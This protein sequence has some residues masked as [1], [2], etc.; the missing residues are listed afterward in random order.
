MTN[1]EFLKSVGMEIKVARI[2]KG[3]SQRELADL[4]KM[5]K[6]SVLNIENGKVDGKI[7][8]YKRISEALGKNIEEML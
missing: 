5:T 4:S 7:L 6:A 3:L 2:R 8:T 1:T